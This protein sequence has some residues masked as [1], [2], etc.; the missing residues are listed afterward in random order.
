[1]FKENSNE[2]THILLQPVAPSTFGTSLY[3]VY[4][5]QQASFSQASPLLPE[6]WGKSNSRQLVVLADIL[7]FNQKVSANLMWAA[8]VSHLVDLVLDTE[9][10]FTCVIFRLPSAHNVSHTTGLHPIRGWKITPRWA[11]RKTKSR[12]TFHQKNSRG[13]F[14][15]C[16][17]ALWGIIILWCLHDTQTALDFYIEHC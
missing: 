14:M 3:P 13:E 4:V 5:C 15:L 9:M 7:N 1:M 16:A 12:Q 11:Q 8:L 10:F 6:Y 2:D 17:L